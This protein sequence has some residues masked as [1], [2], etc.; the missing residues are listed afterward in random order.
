VNA[1]RNIKD[2]APGHGVAA[3]GALQALAG[4]VNREPQLVTS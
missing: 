3:R 2:T 1:A 4:A